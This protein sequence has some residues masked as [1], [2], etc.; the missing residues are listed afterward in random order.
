MDVVERY[1]RAESARTVLELAGMDKEALTL[2]GTDKQRYVAYDVMCDFINQRWTS[3]K[4]EFKTPKM[5]HAIIA[6]CQRHP[7][8]TW[9]IK[10]QDNYHST[11]KKEVAD[12]YKQS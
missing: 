9:W 7:E 2:T 8:A 3:V 1:K 4:A 10:N 12:E 11:F 6:A 5:A